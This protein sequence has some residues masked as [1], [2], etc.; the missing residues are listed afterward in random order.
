MYAQRASAI[1]FFVVAVWSRATLAGEPELKLGQVRESSL[2]PG[3]A[4][5]FVVSLGGGDFA[6]IGVNPRGQALVVKTYDPSGNPFRSAELGPQEDKLN[7]VAEVPGAYRV[8]VAVVDEGATGTFTIALEKVVTL[9][10]RLAPPKPTVESQRIRALRASVRHGERDSLNS[11]W[12]EVKKAGAPLIEPIPGDRENMA[13]TFLWKGKPDTHNVMVLWIPYAGVVPDEYLMARLDGTDVWYKTVKVN[14][15]MR[16]AYTLAPNAARLHPFSLAIDND[17]ITMI[18]A[19][20]RPDPLNPKRWRDD[21]ESVDAPEYRGSSVLEMPDAPPQPWIA[22]RPGVQAGR[23]ERHQ[24]KSTALNNERE[25]AVYL[26]PQYSPHAEPYPLIVL[27]DEDAYLTLI[28]TPTIL[29]NLISEA[30][31]PPVV[32]LLVGNAPGAR[33]RELPCNPVFT[34]A[35]VTELLP[36]VHGLYNFTSDPRH[37]VVAGSSF[38]GLGS[39]CAGL[40]YPETFGNVLAQS[41]SFHIIPSSAG[42]SADSSSEP[43]WVARQFIASPKKPLRFYLNAG[44]AE[45]NA[46]GGADS[47]LFCTRTLRDVLRAKGYEVHYQEFAGGHDSLNWRG[48]LADGLMALVGDTASKTPREH[49]PTQ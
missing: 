13:V 20:A 4:Q 8:E 14:R 11:F 12:E 18:A 21:P 35:L 22:P 23:V 30:R 32:A 37:T 25:I 45:F 48:T 31:I 39:A 44:T 19:A 9:A 3:Q 15:K 10:A 33:S 24:F 49:P 2:S 47:I 27:F 43:N 38:G 26:P 29:D 5:S 17:A 40:W 1:A 7:F 36:W 34:R 46:T 28:P 41:G 16:M 42:D 6:Q